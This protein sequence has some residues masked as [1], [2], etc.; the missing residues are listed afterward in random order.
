MTDEEIEAL[1]RALLLLPDAL[2]LVV[3]V[4]RMDEDRRAERAIDKEAVA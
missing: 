4:Q 2:D 1:R 3:R